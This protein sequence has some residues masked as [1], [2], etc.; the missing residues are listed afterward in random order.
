MGG[1]VQFVPDSTVKS[2]EFFG[3]MPALLPNLSAP[4]IGA[5]STTAA[6]TVNEAK[7]EDFVPIFNTLAQQNFD[8]VN[9][10]AA[11]LDNPYTQDARN[12][13]NQSFAGAD[14]IG[15]LGQSLAN[16]ANLGF[17][18]S[19]PTDIEEEMRRQALRDLMFGRALSPEEIREAQQSARQAFSARG[20][21]T[22]LG[23]ASMEI[24][25]RSRFAD[26]REARRRQFAA[27]TNQMVSDNVLARR[28]NAGRLAALGGT[29]LG[30]SAGMRQ[31][32]GVM[33][34]E[35]DPYARAINPGLS[36]GS[37]AQ[38]LGLNTVGQSFANMLDL[39][40][41]TGSFNVNRMDNMRTNWMDNVGA[42]K[43]GTAA[44]TTIRKQA[45][46]TGSKI[47]SASNR[48]GGEMLWDGFRSVIG[49]K[50]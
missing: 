3:P 33:L 49:G 36:L 19:G 20:L 10:F 50:R 26:D 23:A 40:A 15:V 14:Q 37:S 21:G 31:R 22:G 11:G 41:N 5:A 42:L 29:M 12:A 46:Q 32:G 16:Q 2:A 7:I 35:L 47:S 48:S 8:Q 34:A 18:T 27:G 6:G 4:N 38:Q 43:S 1:N 28:D 45:D 25:N 44:S 24:L 17:S 9:R 30:E 39:Y 13:I